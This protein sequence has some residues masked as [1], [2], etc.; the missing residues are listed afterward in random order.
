M[1]GDTSNEM[2][3]ESASSDATSTYINTGRVYIYLPHNNACEIL[4]TEVANVPIWT[5]RSIDLPK[6]SL[7]A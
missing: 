1:A 4:G 5:Q 6:M 2:G 3:Q 7:M